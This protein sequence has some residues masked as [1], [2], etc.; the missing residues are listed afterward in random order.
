MREASRHETGHGPGDFERRE[1]VREQVLTA[2]EIE[3]LLASRRQRSAAKSSRGKAAVEQGKEVCDF[4]PRKPNRMTKKQIECLIGFF[5][6][7]AE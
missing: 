5:S 3:S 7:M 6:S 4:D 1:M 2:E